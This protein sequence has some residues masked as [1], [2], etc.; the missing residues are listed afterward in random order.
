MGIV[1]KCGE[2]GW[3][4]LSNKILSI[5]RDPF[6]RFIPFQFQPNEQYQVRKASNPTFASAACDAEMQGPDRAI[7]CQ[8]RV[9]RMQENPS[10]ARIRKPKARPKPDTI[11]IAKKR[12]K[13][14]STSVCP[15]PS[16]F[17][18]DATAY[19]SPHLEQEPPVVYGSHYVPRAHSLAMQ[20][21]SPGR[22]QQEG[23]PRAPTQS[24]SS[25]PDDPGQGSAATNHE[26][27]RLLTPQVSTNGQVREPLSDI[28]SNATYSHTLDEQ[29]RTRASLFDISKH[30]RTGINTINALLNHDDN[31]PTTALS[32]T[33]VSNDGL[34]FG[35]GMDIFQY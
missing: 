2:D 3:D 32:A 21:E 22:S 18:G 9:N 23:S 33:Q 29:R 34:G 17:V 8:E 30:Q 28:T 5:L 12:R 4:D 35:I 24:L 27:V 16:S 26:D 1:R 14:G 11:R 13:N 20:L 6:Q 31:I 10:V 15:Q 19:Q 7:P 25:S